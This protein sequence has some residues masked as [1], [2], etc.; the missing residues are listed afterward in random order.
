MLSQS[1]TR[2]VVG[3]LRVLTIIGALIAASFL[4]PRV[5]VAA[6]EPLLVLTPEVDSSFWQGQEGA[7]YHL[8]LE[9]TGDQPTVDV[10]T[11]T[12]TLDSALTVTSFGGEGW[13]CIL[14][15]PEEPKSWQCSWSDGLDP[16]ETSE[17]LTVTF[18]VAVYAPEE[19]TSEFT[20]SYAGG[21][22]PDLEATI[23]TPV[24]RVPYLAITL[25]GWTE[26]PQGK[27]GVDYVLTITNIGGAATSAP[28]TVTS[29]L[30]EGLRLVGGGG[31]SNRRNLSVAEVAVTS[32]SSSGSPSLPTPVNIATPA[33]ATHA[34]S[35]VVS[36]T[37]APHAAVQ[38]SGLVV[39]ADAFGNWSVTVEL[40]EG[41]NLITITDGTTSDSVQIVREP[42]PEPPVFTRSEV[43]IMLVRL[44][45]GL[46]SR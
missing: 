21:I 4:P 37:A 42:A 5:A 26:L 24:E 1:T 38:V 27:E 12:A 18:Y 39:Y 15:P 36:G 10:V 14:L 28:V 34:E 9:N 16:G 7:A 2:F 43:Y 20:V 8:V 23:V 41:V 11:I 44:L 31:Q 35:V 32:P 13:A 22:D 40:H 33:S 17:A 29:A 30:S 19:V 25:T 46:L 45:L 6:G 3:F